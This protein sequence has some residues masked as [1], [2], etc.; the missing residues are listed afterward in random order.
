MGMCIREISTTL[1]TPTF[2]TA[3]APVGRLPSLHLCFL[4]RWTGSALASAPARFVPSC[5]PRCCREIVFQWCVLFA[6]E[7]GDGV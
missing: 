5:E 6:R 2:P 3:A 1:L 7:C 4:L